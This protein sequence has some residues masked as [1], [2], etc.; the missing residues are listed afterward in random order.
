MSFNYQKKITFLDNIIMIWYQY[1][2]HCH[3]LVHNLVETFQMVF[4]GVQFFSQCIMKRLLFLAHNNRG[5]FVP[6]VTKWKFDSKVNALHLTRLI[7]KIAQLYNLLK[8]GFWSVLVLKN[9][10]F[11]KL[12]SWAKWHSQPVNLPG[13]QL[14]MKLLPLP[15]IMG[16]QHLSNC[17]HN[18]CGGRNM[19]VH[20]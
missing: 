15:I 1:P 4:Y 17:R 13:A 18:C 2:P 3:K 14:L 20:C 11:Q 12:S 16:W 10:F 8:T 19:Q 7:K 6:R 5:D 9:K